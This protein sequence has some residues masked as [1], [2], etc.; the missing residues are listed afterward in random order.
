[1][2]LGRFLVGCVALLAC[3]GP[4]TWGAVRVRARFT[5]QL[6]GPV[7]R[8]AEAVITLVLLIVICEVLGSVGLFRMWAVVAA[9]VLI[10]LG[11]TFLGTPADDARTATQT[12]RTKFEPIELGLLF[13]AVAG[14][15]GASSFRLISALNNGIVDTD[16]IWYHLPFAA[17]FVQQHSVTALHHVSTEDLHQF[18][19]ANVELLHAV[20]MLAFGRDI[21]SL[22]LN[23]GFVAMALLAGWC[24]GKP[25]G[26]Q[27]LTTLCVAAVLVAREVLFVGVGTASDDIAALAF[28]LAAVALTAYAS[29]GGAVVL[30]AA[31]A[32]G[33]AAGSRATMI[34]FAVVLAIGSVIAAERGR[35]RHAAGLWVV[36]L[37]AG[38]GF[39][40]LR[41]LIAV[42]NPVPGSLSFLPSPHF[43][44]PWG[45]L[46]SQ[47][48]S[49]K[50]SVHYF[51]A[52]LSF[53][54]GPG[55]WLLCALAAVGLV[56][57]ITR[58]RQGW[59]RAAAVAAAANVVAYAFAPLS[60]GTALQVNVRFFAATLAI[61]LCLL[62]T[63]PALVSRRLARVGAAVVLLAL[64][65]VGAHHFGLS[66]H[67]HEEL[68]V[69]L[70]VALLCVGVVLLAW[71]IGVRGA[72]LIATGCAVIALPTAGYA[73]TVHYLHHRYRLSKAVTADASAR[74]IALDR[75]YA[76]IQ[77]KH[78][79]RVG[80][81]GVDGQYPL[82]GS[83]LSNVVTPVGIPT[84]HG[85]LKAPASCAAWRRAVNRDRFQLLVIAGPNE[86]AK[87]PP[88]TA[89]TRSDTAA[90]VALS[91]GS[92]VT[93]YRITGS[94]HPATCGAGSS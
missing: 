2:S 60:G 68:L 79:T 5:P 63:F 92:G 40:Y 39:W 14:V 28:A 29:S 86:L 47:L 91:P 94:M 51:S 78:N 83:E 20:G 22:V 7:A 11:L 54:L 48:F 37:A 30:I 33:L 38:G 58:S 19:P 8:L 71:R 27:V 53:G 52:A 76:W 18:F 12:P 31:C 21:V 57:G 10:G 59:E 67:S 32:A 72:T 85:G 61:G 88:P 13:V 44:D 41:N 23:I 84:P 25:R 66:I 43:V 56:L 81:F 36:G 42:G 80:I 82:Y 65:A 1:M 87:S 15:A 6:L 55:W 4:L 64:I 24:I 16:S 49:G 73:L 75:V 50:L 74:S 17:G 70:V 89:W 77:P 90:R 9:C 3:V 35:R 26:A 62:V 69:G 46:A 45:K 93:V 34:A